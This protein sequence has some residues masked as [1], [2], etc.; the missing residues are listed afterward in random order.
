M[1]ARMR[2]ISWNP[3]T[4][5]C[6]RPDIDLT[7]APLPCGVRGQITQRGNRWVITLDPRL[8]QIERRAALTHE[9]IHHERGLPRTGLPDALRI[10]DELAVHAEVARRLIPPA[11]LARFIA[12]RR[13]L[14]E[15]VTV[16]CIATEFRVPERVARHATT[17]TMAGSAS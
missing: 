5:L 6:D 9:L 10:R 13:S 3:W 7:W 4:V 17:A 16:A 2:R 12:Q 1:V 15:P 8:D 14:G 11:E